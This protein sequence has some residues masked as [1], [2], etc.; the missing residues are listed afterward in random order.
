MW[1]CNI[2]RLLVERNRPT[3]L[4]RAVQ[5]EVSGANEETQNVASLYRPRK[6]LRDG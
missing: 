4:A 1:R 6:L 5:P 2:L 3:M